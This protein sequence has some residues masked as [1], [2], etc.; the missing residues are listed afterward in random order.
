LPGIIIGGA[1]HYSYGSGLGNK[2][3]YGEGDKSD[4]AL[5]FL[6]S[7]YVNWHLTIG[8]MEYTITGADE[9]SAD[10]QSKLKVAE[11]VKVKTP[12]G[13]LIKLK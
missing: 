10:L 7:P 11:K 1:Q 2:K 13:Q 8:G 12:D 9:S 5:P 6:T 4:G 3:V